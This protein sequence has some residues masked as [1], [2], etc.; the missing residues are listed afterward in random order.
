S[1][2]GHGKG[3]SWGAMVTDGS[4][5]YLAEEAGT[6]PAIAKVSTAG[7][8]TTLLTT[9]LGVPAVEDISPSRSELL[10]T[11]FTHRLGWPLWIVPVPKG[12]PRRVGNILATGAAWSPNGPEIAYV[13]DRNL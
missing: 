11:N 6:E 12:A 9:P 3:Q 13:R 1:D 5:L 2:D 8:E 4:H 10:V 7:G